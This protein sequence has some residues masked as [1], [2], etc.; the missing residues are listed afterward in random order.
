MSVQ[1]MYTAAT[2]MN[3]MQSKLDVISNNLANMET[4]GFKAG[5]AN[6]EDLF[7]RNEKYPG[8]EDSASQRTAVGIAYGMGSRVSSTQNNF[9]QG[10]SQQTGN[11]LDVSIEGGGF[12]QVKDPSGTIYYSRA[13]NFSKNAN[14]NIVVGS[15]TVGRLL[16]PP[17]VIPTDATAVSISADGKVSVRQ[18]SSQQMSQIGQ[19]QLASFINPQGLLQMGENL[20]SETDASGTPQIGNPGLENRGSL[21]QG[22]LEHSNV[23][24][25]SSLI[26]LISTQRAFELNSQAV[27]AGDQALQTVT[28]LIR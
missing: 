21:H 19:I 2:G 8:S 11:E 24:P 17:I 4:V 9:Q 25:V 28:N 27:K 7:Y 3:S 23:E 14:G 20:Y 18:P 26:D 6:F 1:A 10:A 15:A 13:G 22:S 5:R 16:E 12:F